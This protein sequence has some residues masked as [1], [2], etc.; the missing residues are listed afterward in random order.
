MNENNKMKAEKNIQRALL[1]AFFLSGVCG[2]IY[3]VLWVRMLGLIFGNTTYAV[4]TILAGF[5]A[6]LAL[7]S[8]W[9]I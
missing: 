4:S 1:L 9:D 6:G 7:G 2:L 5:M 8:W 3:Q